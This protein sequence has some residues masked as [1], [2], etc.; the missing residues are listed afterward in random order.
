MTGLDYLV[1]VGADTF[2]AVCG[3]DGWRLCRRMP[4]QVRPSLC[5]KNVAP[6]CSRGGAGA[7]DGLDNLSENKRGEMDYE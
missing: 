6:S 5:P 1:R 7:S 4:V 3:G 2:C